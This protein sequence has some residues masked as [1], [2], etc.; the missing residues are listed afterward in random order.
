[1]SYITKEDCKISWYR[2]ITI[3]LTPRPSFSSLAST[4]A[5]SGANFSRQS[6]A[7]T[8]FTHRSNHENLNLAYRERDENERE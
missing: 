3:L 8:R 4:D 7:T 6:Q 5:S 2:D 1:M